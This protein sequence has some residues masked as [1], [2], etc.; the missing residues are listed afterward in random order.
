[1]LAIKEYA[2][3]EPTVKPP[4]ASEGKKAWFDLG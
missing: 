4:K 3:L 2:N 1:M